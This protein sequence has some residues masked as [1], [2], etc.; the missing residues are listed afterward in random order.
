MNL[1][2]APD[3]WVDLIEPMVADILDIVISTWDEMPPPAPEAKED[4]TTEELCRRLRQ[5]RNMAELPFRIDI[6]MVELD[7]EADE[8]QGRMDI[9]FSPPVPREDIYFCLECKRLNVANDN[10]KVR[11]YASEY[12]THGM[13]R[14]VRGQ[15]AARV[16]HGAMLGYVLDGDV[17]KAIK[18]VSGII[19]SRF[20]ELGM[21]A[22]GK[23]LSSSVRPKQS[24]LKETYHAR[25]HASDEF[26]MHHIFVAGSSTP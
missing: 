10:G 1:I 20:K 7:P 5:N 3:E 13:L 8:N 26:Q 17:P 23:M 9:T 25:K 21:E 6:Q 4:P 14:F 2:G 11:T 18:N 12:V 19:K 22:P 24:N 15:Y 16:S